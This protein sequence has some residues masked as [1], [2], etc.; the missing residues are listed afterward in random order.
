MALD[1][2]GNVASATST[3]GITGKRGGRVMLV[4]TTRVPE[5]DSLLARAKMPTKIF[6]K[7]VFAFFATNALFLRVIANL[8][9]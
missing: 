2:A 8:Q 5:V 9:I 7:R 6:V 1:L 4:I 3:G